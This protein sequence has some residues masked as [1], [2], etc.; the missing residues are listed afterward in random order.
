MNGH[1]IERRGWRWGLAFAVWTL[2]GLAFASQL[3]TASAKMGR[4]V[5][6]ARAVSDSLADWYV[7]AL[8]SVPAV[9][10]VRRFH[11]E[12][13]NW[14]GRSALH[15]AASAVF[16]LAYMV[17]RALVAQVQYWASG[18]PVA[19]ADAFGFL[20]AKTPYLNLLVYWVILV[21][22][23]AFDYYRRYHERELRASELE[24]RLV[25]A[26][27]QALQ[28]QL[29]PHFLFNT[30]HAISALM[31]KDVEAAD[32]MITRLSDLLRCALE[33]SQEQEVPL[34]REL[35]FLQSYLE[36]EQTRFG[37]RL[38][39]RQDIAP[40]T[41]DAQVPNLILQPLV[42]NAI[43]HGLAPKAGAGRIELSARQANGRLVLE[44][45][46]NGV[47][48]PDDSPPEEGVGLS[49]T[50]ARLEHLYGEEFRFGL[51]PAT[52]GGLIVRVE[53]PLR[54]EPTAN[55]RTGTQAQP[56]V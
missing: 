46:D 1:V 44:V 19:F 36:I 25:E 28:M 15:L 39:V 47:G 27:L 55:P 21:V 7:F 38:Q 11:F 9:W 42:E 30:L 34:R 3:Y 52:E 49:N 35:R 8:L 4:P 6:W 24:K 41:L 51:T 53:I 45:R 32:R 26:R 43:K 29:N 10:L 22:W 13:T 14:R 18:Q 33:S 37:E 17:A 20:L 23:H 56:S 54:R 2:I 48:L 16:S 12:R 50:R 31:H 5:G 40:D